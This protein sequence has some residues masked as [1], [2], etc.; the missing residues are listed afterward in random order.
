MKKRS[1]EDI[2]ERDDQILAIVVVAFIVIAPI[3]LTVV[4]V[5][6]S[7]A[8]VAVIR[9]ADDREQARSSQSEERSHKQVRP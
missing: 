6:L 2:R 7:A 8:A 1:V 9:Y 4:V 3:E 5:P